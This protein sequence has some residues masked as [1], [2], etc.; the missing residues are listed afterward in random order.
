M[1]NSSQLFLS[2]SVTA[3]GTDF[4]LFLLSL[5]VFPVSFNGVVLQEDGINN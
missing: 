3:L 5:S 2:V 4:L 1:L